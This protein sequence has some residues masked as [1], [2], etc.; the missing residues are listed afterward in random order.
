MIIFPHF[1]SS[2]RVSFKVFVFIFVFVQSLHLSA[3]GDADSYT[4]RYD[5]IYKTYIKQPDNVVAMLDMA[6]FYADTLNPMRNYASAM[7]YI[8]AAEEEFKAVISDRD[9]YKEASRLMKKKVSIIQIRQTRQH[10]TR[11]ARHYLENEPN[12]SD[13]TLD[14]YTAAFKDDATTRRIIDSRRLQLRY[15]QARQERTLASHKAFLQNYASTLEGEEIAKEMTVIAS[16]IVAHTTRESQVD[17]LLEGYL[18]LEPVHNAAFRRK[19][20]I[21][22]NALKQNPT[23]QACRSFLAKYPGSDQYSKVLERMEQQTQLAFQQLS[24]PR[25]YA[26]FAHDNPDNPLAEKA[27]QKL[28]KLI[29]E[30]R[31]I[32]ALSIYMDEFPLDVDYNNIYLT[33]YNWHTEEGNKAPIEQFDRQNPDFPYQIAL[34]DELQRAERFD[35]IDI[36]MPFHEHDFRTWASK[37]YHLTGKKESFVALQRTL[38][39]FIATKDWKKIPQRIDYFALSF[40]DHCTSEVAELRSI[41]ER[42]IEKRIVFTPLVRPAYDMTHPVMHP[43]GQHLFFNRIL[44]GHY[45]IQCAQATPSRKGTVWRNTGTITFGDIQNSDLLIFN[46]F[47]NG[48]KMLVGKNGDIYIAEQGENGWTIVET[49]PQPVNS[50]YNDFDA[51]M[52]PD[53]SGI[54]FAS[55]RPGGKN[56][57]PSRAYFHGDTA[58]A[59]DIY[60]APR[61]GDSWGKPVNLGININSP[62]MECSPYISDDLKTLYFITDGRGGL[63]YGDLYYSTRDNT[64]DW[65]NWSAPTN[66]GKEVNTGFNEASVTPSSHDGSLLINANSHGRYGTYSATAIHT[67]NDEFRTVTIQ[68]LNIGITFQIVDAQSQATVE[69]GS[70]TAGDTWQSSFYADKRYLLFPQCN[71]L[72]LPAQPFVPST[73]AD[74][75]P[76]V[77]DLPTILSLS[78][79]NNTLILNGIAFE[80]N[81]SAL[82]TYSHIEIQHLAQFLNSN[83]NTTVEI[84]I[85]VDGNDDTF[86]YNL[87]QSRAEEVK[88]QLVLNSINPDR[89]ILSPYGNSLTKRGQATTSISIMMH[90]TSE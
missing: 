86:C 37:I 58:L 24:T 84:I 55:D 72:F 35:S 87:S 33:Y 25:Q 77:Y 9:R 41:I 54:L 4:R 81:R 50:P 42:P 2:H 56:L 18:D 49:L 13:A 27:I 34:N 40:E 73:T 76:Q 31:D 7:K 67:F 88:K 89:V 47:D 21:A 71:G 17:S 83:P 68:P 59:S 29:T 61:I 51:Y 69:Q 64:T 70:I 8:S 85:H 44:D 80:D 52:L 10:I 32:E 43:D 65:Q 79:D 15:R 19:S 11:L 60:F 62:Y 30:Q 63:G 46:F 6:E 39:H 22:Y 23:P 90:K 20:N 16:E 1:S 48:N 82:Y 57:Q 28:K 74:L 53:G 78:D 66:Y 3:Q 5:K 45:V 14:S 12:L 75:Q 38:Q 26:D 36:N